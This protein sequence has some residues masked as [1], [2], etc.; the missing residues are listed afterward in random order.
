MAAAYRHNI[1]GHL[2][3]LTPDTHAEI[4]KALGMDSGQSIQALADRLTVRLGWGYEHRAPT[5]PKLV[6]GTQ[7][8]SRRVVQA[9]I[10][11][12]DRLVTLRL[13]DGQWRADLSS[14]R[15]L[16]PFHQNKSDN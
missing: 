16:A 14:V 15:I 11:A 8:P 2:N 12:R 6:D 9:T 4:E 3:Q 10:G 13:V 1:A 7:D 5:P